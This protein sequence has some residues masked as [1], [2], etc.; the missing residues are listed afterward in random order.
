MEVSQPTS[1][2]PEPSAN[3]VLELTTRPLLLYPNDDPTTILVSSSLASNI[4]L[5][6]RDPSSGRSQIRS[7]LLPSPASTAPA[8]DFFSGKLLAF[9]IR[10]PA[11]F[12]FLPPVSSNL[13][14]VENGASIDDVTGLTAAFVNDNP[15]DELE[16]VQ[17]DAPVGTNTFF[18]FPD[19]TTV[20]NP[21]ADPTGD[22]RFLRFHTGEQFS[23]QL[24]PSRD[25]A[26]C[27]NATN[28]VPPRLSFQ[29]RILL[30]AKEACIRY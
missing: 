11:G 30:P 8:Q 29:V 2:P 28:N 21:K 23:L 20:W 27:Q 22:P 7:F 15:A 1:T 12:A 9:G 18:G 6:A 14:V 5:T 25:D 13:W 26:W 16:F 10:N 3:D 24:E 4:D 17:L 19:C